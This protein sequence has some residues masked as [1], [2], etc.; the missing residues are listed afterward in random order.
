[1][2]SNAQWRIPTGLQAVPG[3]FM[4]LLVIV[5]KES[6]RWLVKKGRREEALKNLAYLRKV[7]LDDTSLL[8]EF[9]EIEESA[10]IEARITEGVKWREI[11]LPNNRKRVFIGVYVLLAQ[12]LSGTLLFTYYGPTLFQSVGLVGS[13]TGIFATGIYG[14]VKCI[15]AVVCS[16]FLI[17]RV[18]RKVLFLQGS[19]IM[20]LCLLTIGLL[21]HFYPPDPTATSP[22]GT[23]IGM[24]VLCFVF[25]TSFSTSWGPVGWTYGSEIFSQ[26][27]IREYCIALSACSNWVGNLLVSKVV[28]VAIANIGWWM[29]VVFFFFNM[30]NLVF[31]LVFIKETRG[32]SLEA[33]DRLFDGDKALVDVEKERKIMQ[34]KL[35]VVQTESKAV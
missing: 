4:G 34:D 10:E 5:I 21:L 18:G 6:P 22:S 25:V 1:V 30:L 35:D 11:L 3:T 29:F 14:I 8:E 20:G 16:F 28:P 15:A 7:P 27:R 32:L 12:Q 23:S 9:S 2:T 19:I 26:S 31:A 24:I 13:K 33:M 17:E